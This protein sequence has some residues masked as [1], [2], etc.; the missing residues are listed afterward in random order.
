MD[1]PN[2]QVLGF[3]GVR[4][5]AQGHTAS[6]SAGTLSQTPDHQCGHLFSLVQLLT[7]SQ[8]HGKAGE[9]AHLEGERI[10]PDSQRAA[11]VSRSGAGTMET[12]PSS[13]P[14]G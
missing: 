10:P 4:P 8:P 9:R 2:D 13:S 12:E 11:R 7:C 3:L 5:P 14:R 6:V 1:M